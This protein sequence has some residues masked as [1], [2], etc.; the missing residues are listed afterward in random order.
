MEE[1]RVPIVSLSD[2]TQPWSECA[3]FAWMPFCLSHARIVVVVDILKSSLHKVHFNPLAVGW[4]GLR[5][6]SLKLPAS[7]DHYHNSPPRQ[8]PTSN[9]LKYNPNT[10]TRTAKMSYFGRKW[11]VPVG[12][13]GECA[14]A[15]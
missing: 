8:P 11:P 14:M 9:T 3:M 13:C 4:A 6:I 10:P 5:G 7:N 1:E 15:A 2:E 12:E